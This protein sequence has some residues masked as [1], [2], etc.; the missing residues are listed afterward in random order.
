MKRLFILLVF[1]A[2]AA[3]AHANSGHYPPGQKMISRFNTATKTWSVYPELSV[4]Q[5]QQVPAESLHVADSL[6]RSAGNARWLTQ[7]SPYVNDTVV[8]VAQIIMHAASWTC[9]NGAFGGL[10]YTA[11]GWTYLVHDTAANSNEWG[12]LLVRVNTPDSSTISGGNGFCSPEVGQRV[13][14]TGVVQE[15]P[16]PTSS[17]VAAGDAM[18]STT[19]FQPIPTIA[20][21][22]I[23]GGAFYPMPNPTHLN[24]SDVYHDA[25]PG[26][27]VNY[28]G[29]EP[30]EGSLVYFTH[31]TVNN[32]ITT[33]HGNGFG[34]N[35]W[36]MTDA[37]GNYISDYD[38]SHYW[39]YGNEGSPT[40]PFS[41][42][43][44]PSF[45]RPP[46]FA[47]VDSIRGTL[48]TVSGQE[49]SR[50]YRICPLVIGDVAYGISL[51]TVAT[52]R[53]NPVVVSSSDTVQVSARVA[54]TPG[55]FPIS[56]AV[57]VWSQKQLID[58]NFEP[59]KG[60]TMV[61]IDTGNIYGAN[62]LDNEGNPLPNGTQVRY[63]IKG[64]DDHGNQSILANASL[65]KGSDTS[66]GF[67]FYT[68][69]D[70]ALKITDV[71]YSPYPNARSAYLGG[72]VVLSG[73]VTASSHEIGLAQH[74]SLAGSGSTCWYIQ[75]GNAPWSGIWVIKDTT[76][77]P[78]LDSLK[79]GDSVSVAGRVQESGTAGGMEITRI[80]DSAYTVYAHNRP[81]PAPVD[82]V[83]SQWG[84]AG[85][86]DA[87]AEPYEGMLVR[88]RNAHVSSTLPYF[89]DPTEYAVADTNVG[90]DIRQDGLNTYSNQIADTSVGD[91]ILSVDDQID[92]LIGIGWSS[93]GKYKIVPRTNA[94]FVVGTPY[95]YQ[96][97]WNMVAVARQQLGTA[98]FAATALFPGAG[99]PLFGY[100]GAY[101]VAPTLANGVGYWVRF[102]GAKT[103]RQLGPKLT[104]LNVHVV[105]GW[106]MVGGITTSIPT[107][108]VIR[109][110]PEMTLSKFYG[111]TNSYNTVTQ[112]D[113]TKGYWVKA[114]VEGD[115][116]LN[117]SSAIPRYSDPDESMDR[118]NTLTV[119]D[120]DG[121]SQTLYFGTDP[122]RT[123]DLAAYEMPPVSPDEG[124]NV[125]FSSGRI[126]ETYPTIIKNGKEFAISVRAD[127][128][129]L[130]LKWNVEQ[131]LGQQVT[132]LDA[133]KKMSPL[134]L[135]GKGTST[136]LKPGISKLVLRVDGSAVPREFSLGQNFPNPFN[137]TTSFRFD[138]VQRANV[139]I[140]VYNVIG[141]KVA[142]VLSETYAPG[143]YTATWNGTNDR[144][145]SANSGV[146]F[147]R[148]TA[149]AVDGQNGHFSAL[150]KIV[151]MK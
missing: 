135:T 63:Y 36:Q 15:F 137:P 64:I 116:T 41:I 111:F 71:Q 78:T 139:T 50:G 84:V 51:P 34:A 107:S 132:L 49:N 112:L 87:H 57:L 81:L 43:G 110:P 118:F 6:Q 14:I 48:L 128:G 88:I 69:L 24:V 103:I 147:V 97:G 129:P 31:L 52:H 68:V 25:Y 72:S 12:G 1:L 140:A 73:I 136:A 101:T 59:W 113:P 83:T 19:Q 148:M 38:A 122:D 105:A 99:S 85:N 28:S 80:L 16:S 70:R 106:N 124:F 5:I 11:K 47:V 4:R 91:I 13:K 10:T 143:S 104:T 33:T 94:D 21:E 121:V 27:T 125:R 77:F 55:G 79:L 134:A 150:Q 126:L 89:S 20:V 130:T 145:V 9:T 39:T 30:Y 144:G 23:D 40:D 115:L 7:A 44:D 18:N 46:V 141:Q 37:D 123:I 53:R 2:F 149:D 75:D 114:S 133:E 8:V 42:Q 93:Y 22:I 92:T 109:N 151:L 138:V 108:G 67:F 58:V 119:T 146:Y 45:S 102:N 96:N 32:L 17:G 65:S 82:I 95:T 131:S 100:N 3:G 35:T 98:A 29:G 142:T 117:A 61:V 66:Q 76:N 86:G 90:V 120:K 56:K 62:I 74:G 127:R 26:G 54:E 60:D